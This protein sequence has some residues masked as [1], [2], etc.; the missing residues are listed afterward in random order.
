MICF[1]RASTSDVRISVLLSPRP[2]AFMTTYR[3]L[4]EASEAVAA[5][6][7]ALDPPA[8]IWSDAA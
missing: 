7:I 2:F 1:F 5:F 6:E 3:K 4:Q 8:E